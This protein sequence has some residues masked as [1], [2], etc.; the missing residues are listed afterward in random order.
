MTTSASK[1]IRLRG[2]RRRNP[3][4]T[5]GVALVVSAIAA[6]VL[7]WSLNASTKTYWAAR[8]DLPAGATVTSDLLTSIDANL[9]SA[10]SQYLVG[11]QNPEGK[12][13]TEP[14]AAGQLLP[15]AALTT[16]SES[17]W[18]N[19]VLQ[20][21]VPFSSEL[22]SGSNVDIYVAAR[23]VDASFDA[24]ELLVRG[25]Q[26][27]RIQKSGDVFK[28]QIPQVELRVPVLQVPAVLAAQAGQASIAVI[29]G[30]A[31]ASANQGG[32]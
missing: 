3:A 19:L 20:P 2:P 13:L 25:A 5:I 17:K 28:A 4:L 10:S 8:V 15:K 12:I 30:S 32:Q 22:K 16:E 23:T 27:Y 1:Q 9:G 21:S 18:V 26:V 31:L 6:A 29:P 11:G 24:P 14:L 7:F